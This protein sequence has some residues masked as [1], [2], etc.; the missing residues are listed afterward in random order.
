MSK[1]IPKPHPK[2][3]I[4]HDK[5]LYACLASYPI[6]RGHCV[7]VWKKPVRDL[8]GLGRA[9]YDHLMERVD[10]VRN[11]MLAALKVKKVYLLYMDE[12][13][14]VHWHLVPRYNEKGYDVFDHAPKK[15]KEYSLAEQIKEKLVLHL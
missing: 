10:E 11:A 12:A 2:A 15:L 3:I 9:D 7:V 5:K 4:H 14:H 13:S 8:H 6:T 1:S